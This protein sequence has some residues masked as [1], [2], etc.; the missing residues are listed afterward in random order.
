MVLSLAVAG[1]GMGRRRRAVRKVCLGCQRQRARFRD[2]GIVT[3]DRY[4]TLCLRCFR[5]QSHQIKV[6]SARL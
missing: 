3:W 6:R 4:H 5:A 2:H 1:V